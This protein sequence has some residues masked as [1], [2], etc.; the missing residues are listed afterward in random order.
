METV[1]GIL[2]WLIL[3]LSVGYVIFFYDFEKMGNTDD[4]I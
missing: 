1:Y 2:L 4:E 3:T